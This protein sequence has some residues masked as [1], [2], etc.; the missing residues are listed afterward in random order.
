M[1]VERIRAELAAQH[2]TVTDLA[3]QVGIPLRTLQ[4]R[5]GAHSDF[6]APELRRV[7]TYLGVSTDDLLKTP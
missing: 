7:A 2:V 3:Q 6:T 1:V 5:M 4:R